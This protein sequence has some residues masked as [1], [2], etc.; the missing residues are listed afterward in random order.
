[1]KFKFGSFFVLITTKRIASLILF[2]NGRIFEVN[3][4]IFRTNGLTIWIRLLLIE[5]YLVFVLY[6]VL[7]HNDKS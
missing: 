6:W 2:N 5:K 4:V 7:Y 3:N 1:M